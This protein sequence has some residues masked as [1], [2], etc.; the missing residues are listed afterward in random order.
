MLINALKKSGTRE[1]ASGAKPRSCGVEVRP[2]KTSNKA[3]G[4]FGKPFNLRSCHCA[5]AG[6]PRVFKAS[7]VYASCLAAQQQDEPE[8]VVDFRVF[9]SYLNWDADTVEVLRPSPSNSNAPSPEPEH[10]PTRQHLESNRNCNVTSTIAH[11]LHVLCSWRAPCFE[12]AILGMRA[13]LLQGLALEW[14]GFGLY[15]ILLIL[16]STS[17]S[18]LAY[19]EITL[20]PMHKAR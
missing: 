8:R 15:L 14:C 2:R 6:V 12:D 11:E 19:L 5:F 7:S 13:Q 10:P 9:E 3:S 4:R 18:A 16:S 1:N 20:G 17:A